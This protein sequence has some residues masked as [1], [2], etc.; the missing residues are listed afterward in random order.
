MQERAK[1]FRQA[2]LAYLLLGTLVVLV[3]LGAELAAPARQQNRLPLLLGLGFVALFGVAM[4]LAPRL[5]RWRWAEAVS[6]WLVRLLAVASV[7]RALFFLLHAAALSTPDREGLGQ[8]LTGGRP[9][10]EPLFLLNASLTTLIALMLAR[11]GW[12]R[13]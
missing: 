4:L 8:A 13:A 5:W 9:G 6:V 12:S 3:T 1:R 7:G 10:M 11:A 2:G